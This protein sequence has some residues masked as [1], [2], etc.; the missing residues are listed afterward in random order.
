MQPTDCKTKED[1]L[2]WLLSHLHWNK[3][4]KSSGENSEEWVLQASSDRMGFVVIEIYKQVSTG[5]WAWIVGDEYGEQT[6]LTAE[7]KKEDISE[8]LTLLLDQ[9]SRTYQQ[10]WKV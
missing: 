2:H 7:F 1:C 6:R 5:N 4:K 8:T 3:D 10:A 9:I